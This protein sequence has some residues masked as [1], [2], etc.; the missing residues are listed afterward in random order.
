M[1]V[2]YSS[3]FELLRYALKVLAKLV[4]DLVN[5]LVG[6]IK[7][8]VDS[9]L[10]FWDLSTICASLYI[11]PYDQFVEF[12]YCLFNVFRHEAALVFPG[13][14][15]DSLW[16][17]QHFKAL[18]PQFT[19]FVEPTEAE[20]CVS[21]A[22]EYLKHSAELLHFDQGHVLEVDGFHFVLDRVRE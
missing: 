19:L 22:T 11:L 16:R 5:F 3:V 4:L 12:C 1:A 14:F 21:N 20:Q 10:R 7:L 6:G 17:K 2:L 18:R 9:T 15:I 13:L 8:S